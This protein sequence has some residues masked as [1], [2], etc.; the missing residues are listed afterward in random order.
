M[1]PYLGQIQLFPYNFEP[2]YWL[3]CDGRELKIND[4][5]PLFALIGTTFGGDGSST[6]CIPKLDAIENN[7]KYYIAVNGVFPSRS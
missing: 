4:F 5:T 7:V 1:E 2:S 3:L 6:F